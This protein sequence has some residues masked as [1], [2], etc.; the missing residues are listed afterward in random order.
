VEGQLGVDLEPVRIRTQRR[1]R[2]ALAEHAPAEAH[3]SLGQKH[4]PPE[5]RHDADEIDR[6]PVYRKAIIGVELPVRRLERGVGDRERMLDRE[7]VERNNHAA[8]DQQERQSAH[9]S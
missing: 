8:R 1:E 4:E 3:F 6:R 2:F 9:R 7:M 5:R